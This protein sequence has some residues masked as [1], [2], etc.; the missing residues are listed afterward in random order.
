MVILLSFLLVLFI[1]V[2]LYCQNNF[3]ERN[4]YNIYNSNI[5]EELNGFKICHISDVHNVKSKILV[6]NIIESVNNEKPN[7]I[8][9]T[10]DLVDAHRTDISA[11]LDFVERLKGVAPI[12]YV[13]G[14][15]EAGI[16]ERYKELK[17][18]LEELGVIVLSN[19]TKVIE[20]NNIKVN[21]VGIEDLNRDKLGFKG[22]TRRVNKQL[23]LARYDSENYTILLAHRPE[24]LDIFKN[25]DIDLVLSGHFHGGQI[26]LFGQGFMSPDRKW[27]PEYTDGIEVKNNTIMVLSRGIG[28]SVFPFRINNKP[29]LITVIF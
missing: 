13:T 25:R 27:F 28:N 3:L 10:G 5:P 12:Y 15:H 6:D 21:I 22:E 1:C 2:Y 17:Y 7:I 26:R 24:H 14:N 18:G 19:E 20:Y 16:K 9:I 4:T 11:A 29:E 23:D 8:A